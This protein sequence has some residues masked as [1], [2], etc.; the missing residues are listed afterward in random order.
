MPAVPEGTPSSVVIDTRVVSHQFFH[1][2]DSDG[3]VLLELFGGMYAGLEMCMHRGVRVKRYMYYD[4]SLVAQKVADYRAMQLHDMHPTWLPTF[5]LRGY[6][7][8]LPSDVWHIDLVALRSVGTQQLAQA[9]GCMGP[10]PKQKKSCA[11]TAV[12][13]CLQIM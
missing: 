4:I 3:I 10:I 2:A 6:H 7:D 13:T 5:A 9:Q 8:V 12:L 11:L 1:A